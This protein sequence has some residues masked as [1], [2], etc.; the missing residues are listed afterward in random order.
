MTDSVYK[1]I[2]LVGTSPESWEKA[3]AN[4]IERAG[5]SLLV[6]PYPT[7]VF[8]AGIRNAAVV[9]CESDDRD[10]ARTTLEEADIALWR[11]FI[12]RID[13]RGGSGMDVVFT[14]HANASYCPVINCDGKSESGKRKQQRQ[15]G[16]IRNGRRCASF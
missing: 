16:L 9:I 1:I 13:V 15:S 3:A 7:S 11:Q 4:A 2:E 8:E 6:T 14:E 12:R 5:K 10:Q